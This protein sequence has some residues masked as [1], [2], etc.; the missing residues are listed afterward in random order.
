MDY[1]DI[2]NAKI[3]AAKCEI[4]ILKI[5]KE[6]FIMASN[7]S[8]TEYN[9]ERLAKGT[10]FGCNTNYLVHAERNGL[11]EIE[12]DAINVELDKIDLLERDIQSLLTTGK[13]A[14]RG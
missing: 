7:M 3:E 11:N 9:S 2:L 6:L 12:V 13:R 8:M 4:E 5:R 1:Y 10:L 14:A